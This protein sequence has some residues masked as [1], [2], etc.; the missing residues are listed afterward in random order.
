VSVR[1]GQA[2]LLAAPEA[3]AVRWRPLLAIAPISFLIVYAG[4]HDPGPTRAWH[5]PFA[6]IALAVWAGFLFDD[7]ASSTVRGAPTPLLLRRVIRVL[8]ALPVL[9]VVWTGLLWYA[10]VWQLAGTLTAGFVAQVS[11]A[12][13]FGALGVVVVGDEHGGLVA[14]A[15]LVAVFVAVPILMRGGILWSDPFHTGWAYRYGRWIATSGAAL[16]LLLLACR[17]PAARGARTGMRALTRRAE[18]VGDGAR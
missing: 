16:C 9:A 8:L 11:V 2:W 4:M 5:M 14:L 7:G 6:G 12:L 13:G 10:D 18:P 3:R 1:S 15:G 17:D